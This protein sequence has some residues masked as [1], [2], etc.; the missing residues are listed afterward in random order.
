MCLASRCCAGTWGVG[1]TSQSHSKMHTHRLERHQTH[2]LCMFFVSETA[3][4]QTDQWRVDGSGPGDTVM[5]RDCAAAHRC[6]GSVILRGSFWLEASV[7]G[8]REQ[9]EGLAIQVSAP[10]SFFIWGDHD[11]PIWDC[12]KSRHAQEGERALG[13]KIEKV[14]ATGMAVF[15]ESN[16]LPLRLSG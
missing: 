1:V 12:E 13:K 3:L 10:Y 7:H 14:F 4:D 16:C 15:L 9:Q 6:A 5:E 2:F 8:L 11:V